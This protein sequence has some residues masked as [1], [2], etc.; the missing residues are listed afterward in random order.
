VAYDEAQKDLVSLTGLLGFLGAR[1]VPAATNISNTITV[2]VLVVNG[3]Q[4]AIFCY[5]PATFNCADA[6]VVT[7]N[8]APYYS[9]SA[10][11][12]VVTIADSGHDLT[13]HPSAN[14]SYGVISNWLELH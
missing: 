5:I 1:A 4:D 13:L 9:T 10:D 6:A 7:A 2:P 12:S 8:E 14:D 11:F 3:Q